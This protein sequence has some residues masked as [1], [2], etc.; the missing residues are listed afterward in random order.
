MSGVPCAPVAMPLHLLPHRCPI[1]GCYVPCSAL[2][3]SHLWVALHSYR[4]W[5][6]PLPSAQWVQ[7]P[8]SLHRCLQSSVQ[9]PVPPQP[10]APLQAPGTLQ[11][12]IVPVLLPRVSLAQCPVAPQ[13]VAPL[14]CPASLHLYL[15]S[16]G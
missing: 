10:A 14:Q 11:H 5:R 7:C 4:L 13:P 12:G 1:G 3:V 15:Q 8:T 9:C 16:S 6:V 2:Q